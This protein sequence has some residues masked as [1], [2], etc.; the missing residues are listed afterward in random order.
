MFTFKARG[1][2]LK[3]VE[4]IAKILSNMPTIISVCNSYN[5]NVIL[6]LV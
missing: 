5:E 3:L 4:M 2:V 6:D 1:F